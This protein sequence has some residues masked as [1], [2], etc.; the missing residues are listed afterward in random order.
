MA[1]RPVP[2]ALVLALAILIA[3]AV[4]FVLTA[5][6][7]TGREAAP[8]AAADPAAMTGG[9]GYALWATRADG[10]AARW[11]PCGPIRWVLNPAGAPDEAREVV[12]TALDRIGA[13]TGHTFQYQ[14]L[15]DELPRPDRA[16]Y[17]PDRY[18]ETWAPVLIAWDRPHVRDLPLRTTDRAISIPVAID[19]VFVSGQ[20]V[21]N[22]DQ[23]LQP[24]FADRSRSWG[25]TLVH[26]AGHLVGL[27]HVD[28]P[29]QLMYRFPGEGL[30][31]FG[32][33]DLTGLSQ[34]G[35][36]AGGGACL[37]VGEPRPVAVN[38]G[39]RR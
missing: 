2:F 24:D 7:R 6:L 33:G 28:D 15:S 29:S 9:E 11:N 39:A 25:A 19:G 36:A 13:V 10:T 38:V 16:P 20:I 18:G 35:R 1:D 8:P 26:E 12:T 30:I 37:D 3:G 27:D 22:A 31:R 14:G 23:D 4:L 32:A 5:G 17:Q 34:V 21:L